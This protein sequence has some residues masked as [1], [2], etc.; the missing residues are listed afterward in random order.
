MTDFAT[1]A[2]FSGILLSISGTLAFGLVPHVVRNYSQMARDVGD[3]TAF[4][5][6]VGVLA[7][8]GLLITSTVGCIREAVGYWKNWRGQ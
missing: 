2:G 5:L 1:S 6:M 7:V 8:T 3:A 4:F